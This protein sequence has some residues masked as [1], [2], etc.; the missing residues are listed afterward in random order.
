MTSIRY[1]QIWNYYRQNDKFDADDSMIVT[2]YKQAH[3][4]DNKKRVQKFYHE[5]RN[6]SIFKL[7][8]TNPFFKHG[9]FLCNDY[10]DDWKSL[11]FVYPTWNVELEGFLAP[12]WHFLIKERKNGKR[13]G[14][15]ET[16]YYYN[17]TSD[18][19]S[20]HISLEYNDP[21]TLPTHQFDE[22]YKHL[23]RKKDALTEIIS[24]AATQDGGMRKPKTKTSN[25]SSDLIKNRNM[26]RIFERLETGYKTPGVKLLYIISIKQEDGTYNNMIGF[27]PRGRVRK[28][29][30]VFE[31]TY[32][33]TPNS[34]K[35][36][37]KQALYQ[38]T[39]RLTRE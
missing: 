34:R 27:V 25:K 2:V 39:D 22:K 19:A 33:I 7:D 23:P 26:D 18:P 37:L 15:H 13:V 21:I 5:K 9:L 6:N 10:N 29:G 11:L 28:E 36:V 38:K 1:D 12:H 31:T 17:D 35:D 8:T 14:L 3:R 24:K 32:F 16:V 30:H 20:D 4:V